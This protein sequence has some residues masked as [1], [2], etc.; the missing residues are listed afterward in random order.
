[1]LNYRLRRDID[2]SAFAVEPHLIFPTDKTRPLVD[3]LAMCD[4]TAQKR[5]IVAR[6]NDD[7]L[8]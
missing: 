1:V 6:G 2:E 5:T 8:P 7:L 3:C 4:F